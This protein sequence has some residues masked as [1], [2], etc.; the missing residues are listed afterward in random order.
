MT[1]EHI[2]KCCPNCFSLLSS[3]IECHGIFNEEN[4]G[5]W[6]IH[7]LRHSFN[8]A[9]SLCDYFDWADRLGVEEHELPPSLSQHRGPPR[10]PDID[11]F[12]GLSPFGPSPH[13]SHPD[14]S[15]RGHRYN[16]NNRYNSSMSRQS[17][18]ALPC[19]SLTCQLRA[20]PNPSNWSCS[21]KWCLSCCRAHVYGEP[22]NFPLRNPRCRESG[23][24]HKAVE[25]QAEMAA[26][27]QRR[28]LQNHVSYSH[29]PVAGPSS[30]LVDFSTSSSSSTAQ[31]RPAITRPAVSPALPSDPFFGPGQTLGSSTGVQPARRVASSASAGPYARP[32]MSTIADVGGN[33]NNEWAEA[34]IHRQ[35][36]AVRDII[37][38]MIWAE[39]NRSYK[40]FERPHFRVYHVFLDEVVGPLLHGDSQVEILDEFGDWV[41]TGTA[42]KVKPGDTLYYRRIGVTE[43]LD[44]DRAMQASPAKR[45]LEPMNTPRKNRRLTSE[46]P[47]RSTSPSPSARPRSTKKPACELGPSLGTISIESSTDE[48]AIPPSPKSTP[49]PPSSSQASNASEANPVQQGLHWPPS[50]A[51]VSDLFEPMETI[52]LILAEQG[53]ASTQSTAFANNF[54]AVYKYVLLKHSD[55]QP[56]DAPTDKASILTFLKAALEENPDIAV[57]MTHR[58]DQSA[59]QANVFPSV[60]SVTPV[61][62]QPTAPKTQKAPPQLALA[63]KV[64][65]SERHLSK[66]PGPHEA[67]PAGEANEDELRISQPVRPSVAAPPKGPALQHIYKIML[68]QQ[69]RFPDDGAP[70]LCFNKSRTPSFPIGQRRSEFAMDDMDNKGEM[71]PVRAAEYDHYM[72]SFDDTSDTSMESPSD[73]T[74]PIKTLKIIHPNQGNA[75]HNWY[76]KLFNA[77][78]PSP[79]SYD[80]TFVDVCDILE[81]IFMHFEEAGAP[82]DLELGTYDAKQCLI[83]GINVQVRSSTERRWIS[84]G[85]LVPRNP[86]E[87]DNEQLPATLR[88]KY[89]LHLY[90]EPI[91]TTAP[92]NYYVD[93]ELAEYL[94]YPNLM[95]RRSPQTFMISSHPT[96]RLKVE[97]AD[98]APRLAVR[99]VRCRTQNFPYIAWEGETEASDSGMEYEPDSDEPAS[100]NGD[101]PLSPQTERW[102]DRETSQAPPAFSRRTP[103]DAARIERAERRAQADVALADVALAD[104]EIP[105]TISLA[106]LPGAPAVSKKVIAAETTQLLDSLYPSSAYPIRTEVTANQN[107]YRAK[108]LMTAGAFYYQVLHDGGPAA[109]TEQIKG[110]PSI[111]RRHNQEK[112]SAEKAGKP[113]QSKWRADQ[114]AE[115]VGGRKGNWYRK[116]LEGYEL[117]RNVEQQLTKPVLDQLLDRDSTLLSGASDA[118]LGWVNWAKSQVEKHYT[119]S[120]E[121]ATSHPGSEMSDE[122]QGSEMSDD[123]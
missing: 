59:N 122:D 84:A 74:L 120:N 14:A 81:A 17:A 38:V 18:I 47:S 92:Q 25:D 93:D 56:K 52:R 63:P 41:V 46:T 21:Y 34:L 112:K 106:A 58:L 6:Y 16:K 82:L 44:F 15:R 12:F 31:P 20:Q 39:D 96:D 113:L 75:N 28:A 9:W 4:V 89:D 80:N 99:F 2:P 60:P 65:G 121:E 51:L 5:R 54:P 42:R 30:R 23:H 53:N 105:R 107:R 45:R 86:D 11:D 76:M 67:P 19:Q 43:C 68:Y 77:G 83:W 123:I 61:V 78:E 64:L 10:P 87:P 7:C 72:R 50:N 40:K 73:E 62:F 97:L 108:T 100:H 22:A 49:Q 118:A 79:I 109:H 114:I 119:S 95:F 13:P 115:L 91:K 55:L 116:V 71:D 35:N 32:L 102:L 85:L 57:A 104:V 29:L 101:I 3:L 103:A 26:E 98:D 37:Y 94:E 8:P 70:H 69:P 117:M 111:L 90:G 110:Y 24:R 88:E 33:L 1:L 27:I 66:S 48:D 36:W